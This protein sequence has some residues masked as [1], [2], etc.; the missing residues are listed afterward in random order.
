MPV[1]T[2][3]SPPT[4]SAVADETALI[5]G[6][7]APEYVNFWFTDPVVVPPGVV[8][9]KNQSVALWPHG[10]GGTTAVTAVVP[11]IA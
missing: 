8:T 9:L 10:R 6:G 5:T 11:E 1:I 3:G 4:A 7:E 2:I